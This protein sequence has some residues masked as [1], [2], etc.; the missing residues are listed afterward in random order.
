[1]P[2]RGRAAGV[3]A[4]VTAGD[5]LPAVNAALNGT[6]AVLAL[7]GFAAIR[8][9][10]VRRHRAFMLS[11]VAASVLFLAGYLARIALTG[12]HRFPGAGALRAAYLALLASHT[13]LAAVAAP[14]VVVALGLALRARFRAH[15]RLARKTLPLWLYVSATGVLV[16]AMLYQVAPRIR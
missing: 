16:Y 4:P 9:G 15:R 10:D 5:V 14:L 6:S 12:T 11:A 7:L 8:R 3:R 13:V 2:R 1:M